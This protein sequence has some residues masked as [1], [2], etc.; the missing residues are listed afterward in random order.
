MTQMA[1]AYGTMMRGVTTAPVAA[2]TT[3]PRRTR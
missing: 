3:A 2:W 1:A